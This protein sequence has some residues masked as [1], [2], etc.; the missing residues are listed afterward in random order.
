MDARIIVHKA[1]NDILHPSVGS[2]R[3]KSTL[4]IQSSSVMGEMATISSVK[5]TK[6][7]SALSIIAVP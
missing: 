7:A 1:D 6:F 5:A 2:R 4:P 3:L